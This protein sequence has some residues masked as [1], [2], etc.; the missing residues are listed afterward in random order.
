M[1]QQGN[2][3]VPEGEAGSCVT[4]VGVQNGESRFFTIDDLITIS[5]SYIHWTA[6]VAHAASRQT[7]IAQHLHM[8]VK[9]KPPEC[10]GKPSRV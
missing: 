10:A 1:R 6:V 4:S 3:N 9:E 2:Q 5:V 8:A 7:R